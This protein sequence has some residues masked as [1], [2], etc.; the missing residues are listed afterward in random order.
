M[1]HDSH[2]PMRI[3]AIL[4][5]AAMALNQALAADGIPAKHRAEA[6]KAFAEGKVYFIW[7]TN[8]VPLSGQSV[9]P[10]GSFA[11]LTVHFAARSP[12][13]TPA[14]RLETVLEA[15]DAQTMKVTKFTTTAPGK[16]SFPGRS[17][18]HET[19]SVFAEKLV[20]KGTGKARLFLLGAERAAGTNALSNV[21]EVEIT[22]PGTEAKR[23]D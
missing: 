1:L 8:A 12:T 15:V 16:D 5:M 6:Q 17:A 11:A 14:F 7:T 2:R 10:L 3:L 18:G 4:T 19:T 9:T 22:F 21:L 20:L 13:Q 23:G